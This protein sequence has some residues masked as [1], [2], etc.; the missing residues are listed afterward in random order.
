MKKIILTTILLGCLMFGLVWCGNKEPNIT[1]ANNPTESNRDEKESESEQKHN[2]EVESEKWG[3]AESH[4]S[5]KNGIKS[6]IY[7]NFPTLCGIMEGSGK[8]AY[9]EDGS[10]VI[11]DS[12]YKYSPVID[13][14][15]LVDQVFP[16]YFEQTIKIINA[17]QNAYFKDFAFEITDKELVT[18]NDYEMCKYTRTHTFTF[19]DEPCEMAFVAYATRLKGNDAVAYWMVLDETEDQSQVHLQEVV[20]QHQVQELIHILY[21]LQKQHQVQQ[22]LDHQLVFKIHT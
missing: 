4:I 17:Y 3:V 11:L 13:D 18:V 14:E 16:A 12:Q 21:Q 20:Q 1:K 6:R 8:I 7:I 5:E 15:L 10:L 19:K 22:D 2:G 9:Q